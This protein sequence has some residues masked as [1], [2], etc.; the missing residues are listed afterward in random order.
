M[1]DFMGQWGGG[2]VGVAPGERGAAMEVGAHARGPR[3]GS[4]L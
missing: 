1:C 3:S 2:G 4:P